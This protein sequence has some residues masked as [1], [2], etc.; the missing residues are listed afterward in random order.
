MDLDTKEINGACHCGRVRFRIRLSD[1]FQY[2]AA[3]RLLV[4][5]RARRGRGVG[6]IEIVAGEDALTAYRFDAGTAKHFFCSGVP[7]DRML[8]AQSPR[9]AP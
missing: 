5:P 8:P 7:L 9:L 1:G 6:G 2:R 4:L 3:L